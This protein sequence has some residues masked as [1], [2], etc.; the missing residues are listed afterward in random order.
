MACK[1]EQNE[2]FISEWI[3]EECLWNVTL[4]RYKNR[5]ARQAA[6]KNVAEK[7]SNERLVQG[8]ER[9]WKTWKT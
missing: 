3:Q 9:T 5:N 1:T 7:L 4:E 8:S 2:I 6:V